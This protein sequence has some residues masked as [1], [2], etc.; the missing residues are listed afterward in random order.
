[1]TPIERA[2][3][4]YL[5]EPC[6]RPFEED[7]QIHLEVGFVF[8]TPQLF[9]MGRPVDRGAHDRYIVDPIYQFD[10]MKQDCWHIYLAVGPLRDFFRYMPY[11]LPYMSW[12]RLNM[13]RRYDAKRLMKL[14][15]THE[16]HLSQ[17]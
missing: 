12:E 7:L 3:L 5:T 13:L 17:L 2:R 15:K 1:L 11:W 9:I 8:S 6:A 4:V 10:K 14:C 16:I